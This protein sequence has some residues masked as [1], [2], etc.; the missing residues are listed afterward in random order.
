MIVAERL[1]RISELLRTEHVVT[2]SKLSKKLGVSEMSVRRDL[3]R[4]EKMGI[5]RRTHGGAITVGGT[6]VRDVPYSE[7]EQQ[8]VSEKKAIAN[9]AAALVGEGET[10]ALDGGTT[11]GQMAVALK[12]RKNITVVTNALRVLNQLSDSRD[13]TVVSTGGTISRSINEKPGYGDPCLVGPLAEATMRRFR[14]SKAF[15]ATTG[16]TIPDGLS[17]EVMDQATMKQ[18]MIESSAEII[19]LADHS[20]F[21]HVASSIVGPVTL[22]NRLIT[23]TG[24]PQELKRALEKL[25]IDVIVVEPIEEIPHS[26][27][28][29][30]KVSGD[31]RS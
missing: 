22:I 31:K 29:E 2:T 4:L 23:D 10:I 5:C 28:T 15:M 9:Y 24:I 3:A 18:V 19:M 30:W 27:F 26:T 20:K 11:T 17:N 8:H 14:P 21:G 7:R 16:L 25:G 12:D 6:F 13:L 1:Q